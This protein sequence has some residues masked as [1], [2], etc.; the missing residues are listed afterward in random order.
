MKKSL[1]QLTALLLFTFFIPNANAQ[2]PGWFTPV[3]TQI[4][5]NKNAFVTAIADINNDNYP[6]VVAIYPSPGNIYTNKRPFRIYLN[7]DD[8]ISAN[9]SDRSFIEITQTSQINVIPPDTTGQ[10]SNIYTLADFNNDGNIDI[11]TGAFYYKIETYTFPNDRARVFLGNGAG[12]FTYLPNS[13][14]EALGLKNYRIFSALD[15]DRDGKLDLYVGTFMTDYTNNIWDHGYLLK[16]NGDG[17]FTNVTASSGDLGTALEP[18]YGGAATDY[19]NDCYP[20]IFTAPYCRTNGKVFKNN[21]N[22]TFTEVGTSLG[23]LL[24]KTGD[25]QIGCTFSVIPE[26]SDNDG[27]MD[28]FVSVVHGGNDANEY[29]TTILKNKGASQNYAYDLQYT[30]FPVSPPAST[31]R[32]DYDGAFLDFDNDGLKDVVLAQAGYQSATDRTYFWKQQ[33]N[34]TFVDATSALGLVTTDL[35][36]TVCVEPFDYDLDGDDDVA[37]IGSNT[38]IKIYRN[39]IGNTKSWIGVK[40]VG[41]GGTNKSAIGARIYVYAAGKM[42]MREVMAGRGQHTGQQPFILNFGLDNAT[43]VDSIKVRWPNSSC[44]TTMH[45]NPTINSIVTLAANPLATDVLDEK[46]IT[47]KAFPN[48]AFDYL[49]VQATG[50][51]TDMKAMSLTD[52]IGREIPTSYYKSDAD[53]LILN[54][55]HLATGAYFVKVTMKNG[56]VISEKIIKE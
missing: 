28:L 39:E 2:A 11:V 23:Y 1:T 19:N 7:V 56:A 25:G 34:N 41:N 43:A 35:K 24:H 31:H 37:I 49:I 51:V 45:Y 10:I 42:Y 26:D 18:L 44:E 29:R 50:L 5:L 17:T 20:D 9:P 47:L 40:L 36:S 53:K 14:L 21:G 12:T 46:E 22:G 3:A 27:D 8:T 13:G 33:S 6:D 4:A 52:I 32:G 38:S 15:Y 48:P 55:T 54:V 16:G 30:V